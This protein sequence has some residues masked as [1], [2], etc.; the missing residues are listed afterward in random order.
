ME[1]IMMV[2]KIS[3]IVDNFFPFM[4]RPFPLYEARALDSYDKYCIINIIFISLS[5]RGALGLLMRKE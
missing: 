5:L 4:V 1:T 3:K 2:K